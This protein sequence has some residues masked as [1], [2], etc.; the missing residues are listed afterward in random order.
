MVPLLPY[1]V[2][3]SNSYN[4]IYPNCDK[5]FKPHLGMIFDSMK[6]GVELYKRYARHVGF[7]VRLSS[8]TKRKGVI[9]WKYCVCAIEGWHQQKE[10]ELV[11]LEVPIDINDTDGSNDVQKLGESGVKAPAPQKRTLTR[12]GCMACCIFKRTVEDKYEVAKLH[13]GHTH[14]LATPSKM[15]MLRS[16]RD[17]NPVLKNMLHARHRNNIG[18]SKVLI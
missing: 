7:S 1:A 10:P 5:E 9:Y 15:H 17:V 16:A 12:G 13:E 3:L 11:E 18:T 4:K 6:E 2:G 14:P 8:E